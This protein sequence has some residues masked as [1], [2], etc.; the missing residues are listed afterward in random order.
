MNTMKLGMN[1]T[2]LF[3]AASLS[4]FAQKKELETITEN[5]LKAH[6]EFIASDYM[7]G[8]DFNTEIP[9][10][11]ITADYL[12]AQC[13]KIGLKP[14]GDDYFQAV[15]MESV[16]PDPDNTFIRLKDINTDAE[17]YKNKDI[18][19]FGGNAAEKDTIE[20]EVVFAGYGWYNEET[21]YNDTEGL[22]I[23]DK[24]VLIMTRNIE[25]AL[26]TSI[27]ENNTTLEM[28]KMR[29]AFMG[30]A[31]ALI[32]VPDPMNP[33]K[34]WF[35][36]VKSYIMG[37][38]Y[39]LKGAKPSLNI[40]GKLIFGS[41]EL[42]NE[43]IK[44]SGKTLKQLQQEINQTGSPKSFEVKNVKAEIQ[45]SNLK[46]EVEGKNVI[47]IVEGSDPALKNECVVFTAHYDHVGMTPDGEIN[48]GADDNGSGTVALLEIAEAFAKM[49]KKP[50]R[51]IVFV[52]VTAEEK[53]LIGSD[54]YSQNPII[55]L[56]NTLVDINLDM[57]GRSAEKEP[58]KEAALE[59]SLAG[60]NGIYIISGGQSSELTEISNK[61]CKTLGMVPSDALTKAFLTRSDYFNFYKNGVP[62]LGV[63]TGLHSEYHTPKDKMDKID[64]NKMERVAKYCFL[65]A[66]E[67]ANKKKRIEIDNPVS[68]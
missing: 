39:L 51:S 41:E 5:D 13:R 57:V 29:K 62:V 67:V 68:Q 32:I 53:G 60:P 42:A 11:K 37:G 24:I 28:M 20:G 43:M 12:K 47:G 3:L 1:L 40:P 44:E 30:G 19:M 21:K 58:D 14:G 52:W 9:G 15:D 23:K 65:V 38:S 16:V 49:K 18:F 22:E 17:L 56:N 35:N 2:L 45:V 48:N 7:Q 6:L 66:N 64:Y 10:L 46:T 26:D 25:T 31:K 8:R 4:V 54:Y 61:A 33:D 36:M 55:P 63:S 34:K 59:K 50:R 27:K